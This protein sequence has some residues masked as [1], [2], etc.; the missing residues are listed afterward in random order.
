MTLGTD[1]CSADDAVVARLFFTAIAEGLSSADFRVDGE[2]EQTVLAACD[3][4]RLLPDDKQ[5]VGDLVV[6]G[7][8]PTVSVLRPLAHRDIHR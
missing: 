2:F 5:G 1:N 7:T 6:D 4:N 3:G 8:A